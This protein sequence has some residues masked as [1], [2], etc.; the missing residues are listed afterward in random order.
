MVSPSFIGFG[1]ARGNET[2]LL[3]SHRVGDIQQAVVHHPNNVVPVFTIVFALIQPLQRKR[4][5]ENRSR[6]LE[7]DTV[8]GAIV[9]G[10]R[11]VPLE[12]AIIHEYTA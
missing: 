11:I 6:N 8:I 10:F 3:T 5:V 9:G 12:F 2:N 4:V 1:S 7:L